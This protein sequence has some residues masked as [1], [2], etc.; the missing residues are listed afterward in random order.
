MAQYNLAT[1]KL[2]QRIALLR[3]REE[4]RQED[5]N[6]DEVLADRDAPEV[7]DPDDFL[8]DEPLD[9]AY[10]S[11]KPLSAEDFYTGIEGDPVSDQTAPAPATVADP[12]LAA[13]AFAEMTPRALQALLQS[14]TEGMSPGQIEAA[15]SALYD[16]MIRRRMTGARLGRAGEIISDIIGRSAS[17]FRGVEPGA[18]KKQRRKAQEAATR[19][20]ARETLKEDPHGAQKERFELAAAFADDVATRAANALGSSDDPA[21]AAAQQRVSLANKMLDYMKTGATAKSERE[22]AKKKAAQFLV[23]VSRGTDTVASLNRVINDMK[24]LEGMEMLAEEINVQRA[25]MRAEGKIVAISDEDAKKQKAAAVASGPEVA[26]PLTEADFT[27]VENVMKY[28]AKGLPKVRKDIDPQ[29]IFGRTYFDRLQDP[30]FPKS[31]E[32]FTPEQMRIMKD[33]DYDLALREAK[34]ALTN[35]ESFPGMK[36]MMLTIVRQTAPGA[37]SVSDAFDMV[38]GSTSEEAQAVDR[39]TLSRQEQALDII[40]RTGNEDLLLKNKNMRSFMEDSGLTP[41]Q[42]PVYLQNRYKF[43]RER[44]DASLSSPEGAAKIADTMERQQQIDKRATQSLHGLNASRPEATAP[45]GGSPAAMVLDAKE[46]KPEDEESA[47]GTG[48]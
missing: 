41:R 26:G 28:S 36:E 1:Q 20:G 29:D 13:Q 22:N 4:Q 45:P 33:G 37:G 31:I 17:R 15:Q 43:M 3:R 44:G 7:Q 6:I 34:T 9:I 35:L 39:Q 42:L 10:G 14:G 8:V 40:H 32:G 11:V 18:T 2:L 23:S 21:I 48:S 30:N 38:S 27:A 12:A 47:I 19:A 25:R 46:V 5:L 24:T 16:K